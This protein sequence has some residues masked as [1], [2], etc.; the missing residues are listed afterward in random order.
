HHVQIALCVLAT[1]LMIH[2][3]VKPRAAAAAGIAVALL[4]GIGLEAIAFVAT[5]AG[6]MAL[7]FVVDGRRGRQLRVFGLALTAS[8]VAIYAASVAPTRWSVVACDAFAINSLALI[9]VGGLGIAAATSTAGRGIWARLAATVG[10]G[11]AAVA[12]Y[13][14]FDP[15]CAT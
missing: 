14:V 9:V 5:G 15:L 12:T 2:G 1:A 10:A 11:V 8:A 13:L 7:A 4:L 3:L 6:V